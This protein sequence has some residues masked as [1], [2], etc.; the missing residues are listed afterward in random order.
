MN[1]L[2]KISVMSMGG[3]DGCVVFVDYKLEVKLVV[4]CEFGGMGVEGMNLE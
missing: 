3:C 1:I 4:L 2:Y